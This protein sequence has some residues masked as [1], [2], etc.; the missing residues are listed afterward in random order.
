MKKSWLRELPGA[1]ANEVHNRLNEIHEQVKSVA[2]Y[3]DEAQKLYGFIAAE[4]YLAVQRAQVILR[5]M[6]SE[7]RN[8]EWAESTLA[9]LRRHVP[10]K[11]LMLEDP[12]QQEDPG[13][14]K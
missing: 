11:Y 12:R 7:R 1:A 2:G 4:N 10:E 6:V 5:R 3:E 13:E 14:V 9:L 8:A